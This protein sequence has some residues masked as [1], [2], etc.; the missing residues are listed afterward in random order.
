MQTGGS[1]FSP[2][3]SPSLLPFAPTA[4]WGR[5]YHVVKLSLPLLPRS[6]LLQP[7]PRTGRFPP[8]CP[9]SPRENFV[10]RTARTV[11][12][13]KRR[14]R[15]GHHWLRAAAFTT[16]GE[17]SPPAASHSPPVRAQKERVIGLATL[18]GPLCSP[19]SKE[20]REAKQEGRPYL[21][22]APLGSTRNTSASATSRRADPACPATATAWLGHTEKPDKATCLHTGVSL[23]LPLSLPAGR[24]A[25]NSLQGAT[26]QP[27]CTPSSRPAPAAPRARSPSLAGPSPVGGVGKAF[28]R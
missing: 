14:Q 27:P 26:S 4:Y 20:A 28:G 8:A 13:G 15:R 19:T 11:A 16:S 18:L 12:R 1:T 23:P 5:A 7:T 24:A 2:L 9:A 17:V 3:Y 22:F 6:S 10:R 25:S 21:V